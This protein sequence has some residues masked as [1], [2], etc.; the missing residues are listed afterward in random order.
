[1]RTEGTESIGPA[2]RGSRIGGELENKRVE[3]TSSKSGACLRILVWMILAVGSSLAQATGNPYDFKFQQLGADW[4]KA[5]VTRKAVLVQRTYD[6]REYVSDATIVAKRL[7]AIAEDWDEPALVRDQANWHRAQVALHEGRLDETRKL[8]DALGFV[9]DWKLTGS[10]DCFPISTNNP[11]ILKPSPLGVVSVH[12]GNT[13]SCVASAIYSSKSQNV[14]LRFGANV[15]V[16]VFVNGSNMKAVDDPV[17]FA[18]DQHSVGVVLQRGWNVVALELEASQTVRTFAVRVTATEGSGIPVLADSSRV[19]AFVAPKSK[20]EVADLLQFA[21]RNTASAAALDTLAALQ[22]IRGLGDDFDHLEQAAKMA[23]T[24]ERWTELAK[25]CSQQS[26]AFNALSRALRLDPKNQEAKVALA[27]YYF[28]RNQLEKSRDLLT[29][30]I[31]N[32]PDDFVARKRLADIYAAAGSASLALA[33][34]RKL[35]ADR[36]SSI[37]LKRELAL[38]YEADG[39]TG[40]ATSLLN[41]VWKSSL[42]DAV[43]RAAL[44]RLANRRGDSDTLRMLAQTSELLDPMDPQASIE[45]AQREPAT[46]KDGLASNLSVH[47][48]GRVR[49][50]DL[51]LSA[52]AKDTGTQ[53][54]SAAQYEKRIP[55]TATANS[56][57]S[58]M[59][60]AAKLAVE[61]RRN[62][63]R[64][65]SNVIT[66][67]DVSVERL[68]SNGQSTVHAQQVFLM[69]NDR[70]ARDYSTR[71]IQYSH[72]TQK[73]VVLGARLYKADGRVLE[74]EDQGEVSVADTS[75]S[76]YYDT[77]SRALR[78]ATLEKGDTIELEYRI[79]P[80]SGVN[81]YGQYFGTLIAFQ[82]GLPQ[83]LRR[84]VLI[85][86]ASLKLNVVE[87]R[88]PVRAAVSG[89]ALRQVYQWEATNIAPLSVEPRGPSLTEVAPYVSISTFSD[90]NQLGRWYAELITPQFVLDGE[91]RDVLDQI[92]AN[93]KSE[94]EKIHEIH[95]FVLRNTHY[96]AMEFGVYS[97]KPYAVTQTYARRFGD[98]KDKA[99][100]MIA[101]MR[102]AGIDAEFAL[103][104][105]RKLGDVSERATNIAVFNHAV[106]Y[107]PKYDTW[108]DGTAEYAGSRELPLDD[109]GA[110]ALSV[111]LNGNAT[112]RRI[113]VTLPMQNYTHRV[114]HAEVKQDGNILFSGSAYTRGEDAPG[115]RR[116]YEIAD[117][118]RDMVRA[119]LAQVYPSVQ[120]DSVMVDGAHD[121]ERDIHVKFNGSLDKFGGQKQLTLVSSWLPHQYASS[122]APLNSR[123]QQ[124]QLPA[125]WTTEE[126]IHFVV[127]EK[128]NIE[129]LPAN[130]RNETP[131]GTAVIR[132]ERRGR[133]IVVSTSVQF[134]KLRIEPEEYP[135]FRQFCLDV[136]KA[137]RREIK[138]RLGS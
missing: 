1:M 94:P 44:Q 132:Y 40:P 111:N 10:T 53:V 116:E 65:S 41:L 126:E 69:A 73:L 131:F 22:R 92:T 119:N 26:C 120:V 37:W 32:Q 15:P 114:V 68:Q 113:P 72:A 103:V 74:A 63:G 107:I 62:G 85:A 56:D 71:Y 80:N 112:L 49:Y 125:P 20:V 47:D 42:D 101:L 87:Q 98:C 133:E 138:I 95:E 31:A 9:R 136:E 122:L 106:V 35:E 118:Q 82:N 75:V 115:L 29:Q 23:P 11:S 100:L 7:T 58:Y 6:L 50:A 130:V 4:L 121:I 27:D 28:G 117:R 97:Y 70:G 43:V 124:L 135:Q 109:Q 36:I 81:P 134:S 104:R 78:F 89:D 25:A 77:R 67:A 123:M 51:Q 83:R 33:E 18:F 61:A 137:F 64:E 2:P 16:S 45:F 90:W 19:S 12:G 66:L 21:E 91:L 79:S 108:L 48:E 8:S 38:R 129:S 76:M 128:A 105:T 5:G 3:I 52:R 17:N 55:A 39:L 86:P 88:M 13:A 99:S 93:A 34:C 54:I 30:A 102:A 24:A 84:Y 14:A 59:V 110:M 57:S 60:D 46:V 127:P 96:V